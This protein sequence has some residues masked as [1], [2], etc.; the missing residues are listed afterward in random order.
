MQ[1]APERREFSP[2]GLALEFPS[3][4]F[5]MHTS[6][7]G[8]ELDEHYHR[9]IEMTPKLSKVAGF[10]WGTGFCINPTPPEK[11]ALFA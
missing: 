7:S 10:E 1:L 6:P 5:A 11:A 9:H 8:E 3:Y 4:N 2:A